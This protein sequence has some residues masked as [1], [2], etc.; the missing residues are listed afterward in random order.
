[1][2]LRRARTHGALTQTGR[3]QHPVRIKKGLNKFLREIFNT[4]HHSSEKGHSGPGAFEYFLA[5]SIV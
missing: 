1:V 2:F 5:S 3:P 4:V